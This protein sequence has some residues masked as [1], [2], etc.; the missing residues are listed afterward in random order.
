MSP[1]TACGVYC[2]LTDVGEMTAVGVYR[3]LTDVGGMMAGGVYCLLT[4]VGGMKDNSSPYTCISFHLS[5]ALEAMFSCVEAWVCPAA[6][7]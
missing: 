5:G 7:L 3:L 6:L 2:L 1:T 4:D